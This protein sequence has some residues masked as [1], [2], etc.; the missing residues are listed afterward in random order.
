MIGNRPVLSSKLSKLL[1]FITLGLFS[2]CASFRTPVYV[3]DLQFE[4]PNFAQC[5]ANI[6]ESE[7]ANIT[8][9]ECDGIAISSVAEIKYMPNLEYVFLKGAGLIE[10]DVRANANL[11]YL[12]LPDNQLSK[13]DVSRNTKLNTLNLTNNQLTKVDVSR[14][15][16]LRS[17]YLYKMPFTHIDVSRLPNLRTLGFSTHKMEQIDLS[18]NPELIQLSLNV[19]ELKSIDLS[20]NSKLK[21][22]SLS[23]NKLQQIDLSH[24]PELT[25]LNVRNNQLAT[26][27]LSKQIVLSK[28]KADYNR[29]KSLDLAA[30]NSL[31][32]IEINNNAISELDIQTHLQLKKFVAFN[33]PLEELTF[34]EKQSFEQFSIE[35]TPLLEAYR[36]PDEPKQVRKYHLPEV[37]VIDAGMINPNGYTVTSG[38]TLSPKIGDYFGF[39]YGMTLRKNSK[40][41]VAPILAGRSQLPIMVRMVHPE[42]VDPDTGE[43]T[44][45]HIWSDT[46]FKHDNNLAMW[47]FSNERELV[48]GDWLLQIYFDDVLMA[49]QPF[50]LVLSE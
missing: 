5:I 17:L 20:H 42:F 44:H 2:G 24:N 23:T 12:I 38:T 33:N 45:A 26:L 46:M 10:I 35:N 6:G 13:V 14:N 8:R 40:G 16:E 32:E 43:A 49:E 31:T 50:K 21:F 1:T 28:L 47:H 41:E 15:Q 34:D 25:S 7:L 37:T 22:L 29:L 39:R 9:I 48:A 3:A 36:K 30:I 19:G 27:D 4:D 11:K 18:H